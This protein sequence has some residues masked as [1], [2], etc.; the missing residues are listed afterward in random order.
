MKNEK[1]SNKNPIININLDIIK[2]E[3]LLL[4]NECVK[5]FDEIQKK[6]HKT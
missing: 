6:Y 4:K 2:K 1:D 5:D 3:L